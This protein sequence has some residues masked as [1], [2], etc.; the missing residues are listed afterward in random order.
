[1]ASKGKEN[2]NH[3]LLKCTVCNEENYQTSK[4]RKNDPEKLE[5]KKY[6]SRCNKVTLHREKSK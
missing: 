5:I 3:I 1:M 6:C 2:R 4:N